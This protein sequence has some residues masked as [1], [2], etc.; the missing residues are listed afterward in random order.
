MDKGNYWENRNVLITGGTGF[1][2]SWLAEDLI[3]RGA[4][5]YLFSKNNSSLNLDSEIFSGD[6]LDFKFIKYILESKQITDVFHLAA[7]PLPS[8]GI[9]SPRETIETNVMGTVNVLDACKK[10]GGID[11]IVIASSINAYGNSQELPFTENTLFKKG[12]PY[13]VSKACTDE[14]ARSFAETFD[15]PIR[16]ARCSN[17]YGPRDLNFNRLVP[18]L[19]KCL[20]EDK[21]FVLRNKGE[22]KRGFFYIKDAIDGYRKLAE[23]H[24]DPGEAFNLGPDNPTKVIE[25]VDKLIGYSGKDYEKL[26]I[27]PNTDKEITDQYHDSSKAKKK[28]GWAPRYN[29][30]QGLEETFIWYNKYFKNNDKN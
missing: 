11:S 20:I 19:I 22:H 7:Q 8:E 4:K 28:L 9:R 12:F 5:V 29:L 27:V 24:V 15:L 26:K 23:I 13:D 14:I 6:I 16:I 25:F 21:E 17:I 10:V 2:G 30:K 18:K 3:K 1:V